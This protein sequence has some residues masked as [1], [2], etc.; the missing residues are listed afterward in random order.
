MRDHWTLES[1]AWEKFDRS[2]LD[3]AMLN[4]MKA[5]SLVEYNAIDYVEYLRKV[6]QNEPGIMNVLDR[7]G[8]E[9]V[10]H[11]AALGRWAEIADP[12]FNFQEAFARF[13]KAYRPPHFVN[14]DG[15][16]R[17][18]RMGELIA[19]CVVECGTSSGY[20]AL[21]DAA[22]EPVLKQIAGL[23]A[24]DEFAHYRL[25]LDLMQT[26]SEAKLGFWKRIWIAATRVS[27]TE[28]DELAMA[29]Y[30]A[31]VPASR[32]HEIRYDRNICNQAYQSGMFRLY[33]QQHIQSA[34]AMTGKAIGI[35]PESNALKIVGRALWQFVRFRVWRYNQFATPFNPA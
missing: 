11:G 1:I 13:R 8:S 16:V 35:N 9:E 6:F 2:K 3:P 10:Q 15:S 32:E 12:E 29:Y 19:R 23:V 30:C 21:R 20:T 17:G 24:A 14:G 25:F 33:K 5:A 7:W 4:L 34:V 26:Q 27:E 18:S 22:D 28:D 31:N